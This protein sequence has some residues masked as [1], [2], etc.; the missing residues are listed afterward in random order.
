MRASPVSIRI[1]VP[2]LVSVR[3]SRRKG[4]T[5]RQTDKGT[6]HLYIVDVDYDATTG[7]LNVISDEQRTLYNVTRTTI[8][9]HGRDVIILYRILAAYRDTNRLLKYPHQ[10]ADS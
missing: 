8:K 4:G 9:R 2:N 10:L 5:D 1:G 3:W 6:L 7:I